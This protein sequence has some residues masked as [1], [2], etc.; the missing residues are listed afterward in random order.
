VPPVRNL[1]ELRILVQPPSRPGLALLRL[2]G[3]VTE[4]LP[5]RVS[6]EQPMARAIAREGWLAFNPNQE[7]WGVP[8][9]LAGR[10]FR[11]GGWWD[12][13]PAL[14][15]RTV[16][17]ANP[18]DPDPAAGLDEDAPAL[19]VEYD[20]VR[21]Q[22]LSRRELPRPLRVEAAV[23]EGLV[24][25]PLDPPGDGSGDVLTL[26]PWGSDSGE[27]LAPGWDVL[28]CRG[29]VLAVALRDG[30]LTLTD[31]ATRRQTAVARP[32]PGGWGT[33]GSF[34]PDG[35]WFAI[36]VEEE[37]SGARSARQ[38]EGLP[39]VP[40][41]TDVEAWMT[42][43]LEPAHSDAL[44]GFGERLAEP[45][46]TRLALIRIATG[47]VTLA[48]GRFDNFATTPVWS[49]DSRR[50]IFDAPFDRSLFACDVAG[51]P[52]RLTAIVR[53]RGRPTPL[54]DVTALTR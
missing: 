23:P 17:L 24:S 11:V 32:L 47:A 26:W 12:C 52:P 53:R 21:R 51:R 41:G 15:P 34:S 25:R 19:L 49:A 4:P 30:R 42:T 31:A 14:N 44:A 40:A 13:V 8:V 16:W 2:P 45:R 10:A 37:D 20:G 35:A 28:A 7:V 50:L 6:A 1:P 38:L 46:W 29:S 36:G 9:P 5:V 54:I 18:V 43:L 3:E 27:P 48:E 33:F 22:Q 39:T